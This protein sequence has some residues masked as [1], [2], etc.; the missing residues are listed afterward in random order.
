MFTWS[1]SIALSWLWGLGFFFSIHFAYSYGIVGL[2]LFALP[3]AL[4]LVLFGWIAGRIGNGRELRRWIEGAFTHY[5]GVF[6]LYQIAALSLTLFAVM[7]YLA[8]PAGVELPLVLGFAVVAISVFIA[9]AIGFPRIRYLHVGLFVV[10]TVAAVVLMSTAS[11]DVARQP[12]STLGSSEFLSYLVPM[13]VGLLFG[14]WADLQQ[15]QRAVAIAEAGRSVARTFIGGAALFFG[16]LMLTGGVALMVVPNDVVVGVSAIDGRV[17]AEGVVTSVLASLDGGLFLPLFGLMAFIAVVTTCDSGYLATRWFLTRTEQTAD[18]PLLALLPTSLIRSPLPVFI[19]SFAVAAAAI[20]MSAEL[21]HFMVL[22]ATF[23]LAYSA[24]LLIQARLGGAAKPP[25]AVLPLAGLVSLGLLAT[26]Y[27]EHS[28]WLMVASAFIP[29]IGALFWVR[30]ERKPAGTVTVPGGDRSGDETHEKAAPQSNGSAPVQANGQASSHQNGAAL[31][32]PVV[33]HG[34][35]GTNGAHGANGAHD[36]NGNGVDI[37]VD[38]PLFGETDALSVHHHD[39]AGWFDKKWFTIHIVPTYGDTNSVGN[40]Y[41]ASYVGWVG[42]ARE[43]FFRNCMP[44]FDLNNSPYFILTRNF[45]HKFARE[46]KEF[47]TLTVRLKIESFNR[48]FVKLRH[49]I[50]DRMNQMIGEGEQ[51]LMFVES[52]EYRLIDIPSDVYTAFI[53]HA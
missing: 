9:E 53:P 43:L 49:E 1:A 34:V 20:A 23:F 16:L 51:T 12:A 37:A 21:E 52:N 2:V 3:N 15:W 19:L 31:A 39:L 45:N 40:V 38:Q 29:V 14:P 27:F 4:G 28:P 47:E 30:H 13:T 41:F 7:A 10:F 5:G 35:N 22:F 25:P 33:H 18:N 32:S 6:L 11:T 8:E 24:A 17:H 26:G 50:R 48:K 42:K 46:T 36:I 44:N